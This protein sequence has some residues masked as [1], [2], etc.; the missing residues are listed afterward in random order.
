[1]TAHMSIDASDF[2]NAAKALEEGRFKALADQTIAA[3]L[4]NSANIVRRHVR[5]KAKSHRR[6]GKMAGRVQYKKTGVGLATVVEVFAGGPV[7]HLLE[8]GVKP[9]EIRARGGSGGANLGGTGRALTIRGS[10]SSNSRW[11]GSGSRLIKGAGGDVLA[12]RGSVRHPGNAAHPFFHQGAEEA[13]PEVQARVDKGA[14]TMKRNL[15]FAL[16][17]RGGKA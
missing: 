17:G 14:D 4:V 1:M 9:H 13:Q 12:V 5:D 15:E 2:K 16:S 10:A 8:G 3:V 7:A 11:A 6:T